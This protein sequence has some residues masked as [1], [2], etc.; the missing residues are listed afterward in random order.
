MKEIEEIKERLVDYKM[1]VL[2]LASRQVVSDI[3][4][5]LSSLKKEKEGIKTLQFN[6]NEMLNVAS[7]QTEAYRREKER[8]DKL[9]NFIRENYPSDHLDLV[10]KLEKAEERVKELE[11]EII[12]L[13]DIIEGYHNLNGELSVEKRKLVEMIVGLEVQLVS[14]KADESIGKLEIVDGFDREED[15]DREGKGFPDIPDEVL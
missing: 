12:R 1:E 11:K 14:I 2:K 13:N 7:E 10:L 3:E 15:Y 5:L 6:F 9:N 8:A 4:Y